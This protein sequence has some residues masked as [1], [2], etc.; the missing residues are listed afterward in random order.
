MNPVVTFLTALG[1]AFSALTL[2]SEA[3]PMRTAATSRLLDA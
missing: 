3:H 2:Y 1:Q